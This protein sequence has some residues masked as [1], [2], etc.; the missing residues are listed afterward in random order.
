MF[1]PEKYM[2]SQIYWITQYY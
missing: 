1:S 2:N